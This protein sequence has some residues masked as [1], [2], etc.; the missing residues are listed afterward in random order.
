MAGKTADMHFIN[1]G[2]GKRVVKGRVAGPIIAAGIG[3]HTFHGAGGVIARLGRGP[4]AVILGDDYS[5]AIRVK[6]H[7]LTIKTETLLRLK[8][9]VDAIAIDLAGF[10]SRYKNVPVVESP[11]LVGVERDDPDRLRIVHS[12]EQQ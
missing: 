7:F 2:L 1:D 9:T 10:E 8:G 5:P 6:Q 3:H 12:F 11:V 4:A